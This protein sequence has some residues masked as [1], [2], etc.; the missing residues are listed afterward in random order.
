MTDLTLGDV[1]GNDGALMGMKAVWGVC[2]EPVTC[3]SAGRTPGSRYSLAEAAARHAASAPFLLT[4]GGGSQVPASLR[5]RVLEVERV[6]RAYGETTAF[7]RDPDLQ[8]GLAQWPTAVVLLEVWDVVGHPH[9]VDDLGFPDR[10]VL[11]QAFDRVKSDTA[12]TQ[13]LWERLRDWPVR[14]RPDVPAIPGFVDPP[15]ASL[16]GS[17]YPRISWKEAEGRKRYQ[18]A[19]TAE[20][21]SRA[22]KEAKLNNRL[23]NGGRLVCEACDFADDKSGLFDSHHVHPIALGWRESV[24]E[25]FAVLCPT[26]H[27]WAHEKAEDRLTPLNVPEIRSQR[28]VAQ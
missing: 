19:Q 4:I 28:G 17:L 24:L 8:R 6:S 14:L 7:V 5:G 20:R 12:N 13:A 10:M 15:K 26:C 22:A 16:W 2:Q 9:L 21:S 1:V 23:R 25:D 3:F 18:L 11:A 27:R